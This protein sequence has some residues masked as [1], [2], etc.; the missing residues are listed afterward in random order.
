MRPGFLPA[1]EGVSIGEAL[2]VKGDSFKMSA[3]AVQGPLVGRFVPE[4]GVSRVAALAGFA[5]LGSLILWASAKIS[6]PFWPV[7]MTLQTGAVALIAAAYGW[8]LGL[9]TVLLYLARGCD[10]TACLPR[11]AAGRGPR[12]HDRPDGRLSCSVSAVDGRHHRLVCGAWLRTATSSSSSASWCSATR[13]CSPSAWP[14][15]RLRDRLGQA[16]AFAR[17]LPVRAGRPGE[18]CAR[19]LLWS[20]PAR[21]SSG[22]DHRKLRHLR[23]PSLGDAVAGVQR[24]PGRH[25]RGRHVHADRPPAERAAGMERAAARRRER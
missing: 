19:R 5:I 22:A 15:A 24:R 13:S 11:H 18:A 16:G 2:G 23:N 25:Q 10:G 6:V 9:A 17:P 4:E 12:L 7:P 3:V 14:M 1:G 20:P 21:D 8:R